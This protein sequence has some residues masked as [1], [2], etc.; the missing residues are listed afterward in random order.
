MR[1]RRALVALTMLVTS[2]TLAACEEVP[3]VFCG[4]GAEPGPAETG[5][6]S[7]PK[8][9]DLYDPDAHHG[10]DDKTGDRERI[11]QEKANNQKR[12]EEMCAQDPDLC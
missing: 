6:D 11:A 5:T 12:L 8:Q 9:R 10:I 2:L 4:V 1:A 7:K 3:C